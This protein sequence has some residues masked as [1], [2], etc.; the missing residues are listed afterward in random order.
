MNCQGR[1]CDVLVQVFLTSSSGIDDQLLKDGQRRAWSVTSAFLA[2]S[3]DMSYCLACLD[4]VNTACIARNCFVVISV[5]RRDCSVVRMT[6][7]S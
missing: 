3:L 6:V 2:L 5:C 1:T 7:A 4:L